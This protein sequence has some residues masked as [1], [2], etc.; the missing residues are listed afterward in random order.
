[1]ANFFLHYSRNKYRKKY[2]LQIGFFVSI[3]VMLFLLGV[4][5]IASPHDPFF[6]TPMELQLPVEMGK[7]KDLMQEKLQQ[8]A[9]SPPEG[10]STP[11]I[12]LIDQIAIKAM[13]DNTNPT[14][15]TT[16]N[17]KDTVSSNVL[18]GGSGATRKAEPD[19]EEPTSFTIIE[20]KPVYPGGTDA[21]LKFLGSNLKYPH[22]A[23]EAGILGTVIVSFIVEKDGS[24]TN[25]K[26]V[27]GLG[28][29]C[30]DEAIR[31][32]SMMPKWSPGKQRSKPVRCQCHIPINFFLHPN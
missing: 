11:T 9:S 19:L 7:A 18:G 24:I 25:V 20:E 23:K 17:K 2:D 5:Y 30:N 15:T 27:R 1:M 22:I 26:I 8:E 32:I 29:G 16:N 28:G 12:S 6:S 14:D 3:S 13:N 21:M 10:P 31:V 4:M